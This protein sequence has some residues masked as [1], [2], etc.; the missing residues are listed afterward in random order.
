MIGRIIEALYLKI[1]VN[2]VVNHTTSTV[3]IE[4]CNKKGVLS[5]VSE[6]FN[7]TTI[8]DK[9]FNFINSYIKDTP[10]FYITILDS[11]L[12][13]GALSSCENSYISNFIEVDNYKLICYKKR[14]SF[15]TSKDSIKQ[16]Y[17][18]Y[19]RV[20][21][22][23]IFS[24][25]LIISHFFKDKI[26]S[27]LALFILIEESYLSLAIFDNSNLL[28]AS[29]LNMS[30][31]ILDDNLDIED[32]ELNLDEEDDGIDLE[33]IDALDELDSL[34][35]LDDFGDIED[36]DAI[37][38]ID[39]FS[40]ARDFEE[41]LQE[42]AESDDEI[43]NEENENFG[44]DYNRY[45]MIQSSLNNFYQDDK[46]DSKFIETVYIADGVGVSSDLKKYLEEELF[47]SVYVRQL[48]IAMELCELAKN[49][50]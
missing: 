44:V 41:E 45:S 29:H 5:S 7:T 23:F 9:M 43:T 15:Y 47:L 40:D 13:Q 28:Y 48:D 24:P 21:I 4:V 50:I 42:D 38:D 3:Y 8:N 19:S 33:E 16:F 2:I 17:K 37:D 12:Y 35:G 20:G 11:S 49:E 27:H 22:D 39:E 32:E 36:L 31:D 46:Y 18:D 14:Y 26:D 25:F 1:F 34:D 10:Y 6:E 30:D